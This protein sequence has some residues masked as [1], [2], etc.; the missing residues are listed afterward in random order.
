MGAAT[1]K[2]TAPEKTYQLEVFRQHTGG[3]NVMAM[4]EDESLLATGGDDKIVRVWTTPGD[5]CTCMQALE[6]HTGIIYTLA[7]DDR[8]LW[9]GGA[10]KTVR[11]WEPQQGILL[12]VLKGHKSII[13]K[14]MSSEDFVLSSSY[15]RTVRWKLNIIF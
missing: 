11:K 7:F 12:A 13:N 14:V 9:S 5:A 4:S 6:G 8:F 1:S 10:D 2:T 3:I 15:D